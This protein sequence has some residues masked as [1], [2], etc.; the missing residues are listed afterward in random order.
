MSLVQ[1]QVFVQRYQEVSEQKADGATYTPKIL[2]DFVASQIVASMPDFPKNRPVRVLEP[3]VGD[4]ELLI[5][6]IEKLHEQGVRQIEIHAFET[7]D[8]AADRTESRM[9]EKFPFLPIQLTR[10]NFLEFVL[11]SMG[12][13]ALFSSSSSFKKYDLIIAN[14]PY[15]R[16]Q[17]MGAERSQ[18]LAKQ[19]GLSGRVDLYHAF[20]VGM[21]QVMNPGA[22]AGVIV[23]NRFMT[24]KSGASI[25][26]SIVENF[27]V[28]HIWDLGDT[29]IF[30][31]AVLPAVLL[32]EKSSAEAMLP[33]M[34]TSIYET[35]DAANDYAEDVI[36]ALK[37][38]GIVEVAAGRRFEVKKGRL[39]SKGTDSDVWRVST[40]GTD[41]WFSQVEQYTWKTFRDIGK[42]RVGVK[43]CA[44]KIFIRSDWDDL[45]NDEQPELLRH[46]ITHHVSRSFRSTPAKKNRRILYPHTCESGRRT[47]VD[48]SK[49]PKAL[50]YLEGH[51]AALESRTYV[52]EA[53]RQ[54]YELWVPQD[55]DGWTVPKLVFRDISE[56]PEFWMDVDGGVVN[57]DCYWMSCTDSKDSELLWLAAAVANS[58]FIESFYDHRFNNKLYAGRRRFI[59]QYVE[60]FPIPDPSTELSKQ[61]IDLSKQIFSALEKGEADDLI[62]RVNGL[63]WNAFGFSLEESGR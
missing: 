49:Y 55:P 16:T 39:D 20:L 7:D 30:E 24:T 8:L 11:D 25:R 2:A 53:G 18:L 12:D 33:A 38:D 15:V 46:L 52:I 37:M 56:K 47:A 40:A 48:I 41:T 14:P 19:F 29:K 28:R 27:S 62:A 35:K 58:T 4:G 22:I 57:G 32:L 5:S 21:A 26:Q 10:G 61:I 36:A 59:T 31:A 13:G 63:V 51:R 17:I 50:A 42:I 43:T 44:D 23:S 3:A 34:F 45:S 9:R 60:Q 54:W 1:E 6:L